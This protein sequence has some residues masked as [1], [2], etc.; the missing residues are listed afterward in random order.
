MCIRDRPGTATL[1]SL[2]WHR[3]A[4]QARAQGEMPLVASLVPGG[5]AIPDGRPFHLDAELPEI[6]LA[7]LGA[8]T[9]DIQDPEGMLSGRISLRG[10][11]A[12]PWASGALS[13]RDGALRIPNREERIHDI[14]GD[15][16]LDSTGVRIET[17]GGK[18]GSAG[19][20]RAEGWFRS[21]TDFEFTAAVQDATVFETGLYHF[22]VDGEIEVF[23]VVSDFGSYYQ[24]VGRAT[25]QEGAI[26]GDLA[27]VPPPPPRPP[28][29][30]PPWRAEI[31]IDA[32]GNVRMSTAVASVDLGRSEDLH[33]SFV[34]PLINISGKVYVLGGRYRVFN[35]VF[36]ITDGSVEFRDT[37][38]GPEPIL[39]VNAETEVSDWPAAGEAGQ[40]VTVRIHATGPITEL[41]IDFTSE[42]ARTEDE[43]VELLSLGRWTGGQAG[44][45]NV[46]DPSRQYIFTELVSQ[47]ESQMS[48][49]IAPLENVSVQPGLGPGEAWK[50]NVRQNVL[51]QVQLAY[52][53][54]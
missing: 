29:K 32:P 47:I 13:I 38:R 6:D 7:L 22:T 24:A 44:A 14:D 20:A 19:R 23:P 10:T 45:L 35:N 33:L 25:V 17:L 48:Q 37:G 49:M 9:P 42:P 41:A 36:T 12:A 40:M 53:C 43:I 27:K 28:T 5:T 8:L 16:T 39:D 30:R 50:L 3:G 2:V 21:P 52:T 26:V 46:A 18:V 34:E 11:R 15:L 51:P 31:D 1:D 4:R 54:L